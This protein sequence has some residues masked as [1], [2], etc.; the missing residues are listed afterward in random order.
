MK[1]VYYD[2]EPVNKEETMI[3]QF[4]VVGT[5]KYGEKGTAYVD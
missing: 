1:L 4:T 5:D 3:R 2:F